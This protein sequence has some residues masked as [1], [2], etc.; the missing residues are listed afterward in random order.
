MK[1]APGTVDSLILLNC[2]CPLA[3]RFF[4]VWEKALGRKQRRYALK[5]GS[6]QCADM[7]ATVQGCIRLFM[8]IA[9]ENRGSQKDLKAMAAEI[10]SS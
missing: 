1:A 8:A 4:L 9:A 7:H 10:R 3:K 2:V 5:V 6:A